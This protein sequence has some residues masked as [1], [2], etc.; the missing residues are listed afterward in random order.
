L[1][2]VAGSKAGPQVSEKADIMAIKTVQDLFLDNLR[3][4]YYAEKQ[5]LKA[6]PKMAKKATH[7]EL[8]T[9][10][11][12]H[13]EETRGQVE[14][15]EQVF[16]SLDVGKRAK[17]CEAMEGLLEEAREH[18]EEIEDKAVLDVGMTVN[19]QKVEH[20]EIASYGSLIAIA[21]QLGHAD[22][23]PLLEQNLE[24]EKATDAKLTA[25]AESTLNPDAPAGKT[26]SGKAA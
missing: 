12:S 5:L 21:R 13:A 18:M 17:R 2:G 4:I 22:A 24:E 14:R 15:I 6:L 16:E 9:A 7:P 26:K 19:A 1:A 20:Y 11:E 3:D 8:K 10:F 23:V 25:I